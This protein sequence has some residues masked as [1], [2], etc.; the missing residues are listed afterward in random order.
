MFFALQD[1]PEF[2]KDTPLQS[3]TYAS[4]APGRRELLDQIHLLGAKWP[5]S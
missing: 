1:E 5:G 3:I 2:V 4:Y